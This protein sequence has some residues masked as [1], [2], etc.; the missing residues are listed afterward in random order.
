MRRGE[1]YRYNPVTT[2]PQPTLRLVVA[3]QAL[4]DADPP[5]PVVLCLPIVEEDDPASLLTPAVAGLGWAVA[6][7]IERTLVSRM[8]EH[9]AT[10]SADEM[11][12]VAIALRAALDL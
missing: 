10:A 6:T 4:L 2:R 9:V 1:I 11:E 7:N 3:A 8:T 5:P 12:Q